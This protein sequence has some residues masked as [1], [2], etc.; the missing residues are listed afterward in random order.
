MLSSL[1]PKQRKQS[2]YYRWHKRLPL[3]GELAQ[4][5]EA[6][7]ITWG[8]WVQEGKHYAV[9]AGS[10][11]N[12]EPAPNKNYLS[13]LS[14][15]YEHQEFAEP[16]FDLPWLIVLR[17]FN[18]YKLH[19]QLNL[20]LPAV[21][22]TWQGW[23]DL[24]T[25]WY[26]SIA[27]C[28][29][30]SKE[31]GYLSWL[32]QQQD[33][34]LVDALFFDLMHEPASPS[35]QLSI[36][37]SHHK[38]VNHLSETTTLDAQED[39]SSWSIRIEQVKDLCHQQKLSKAVLAR[40]WEKKPI[41]G[42]HWSGAKLFKKLLKKSQN[43]E[44][45]FAFSLVPDVTFVGLSP[46]KLFSLKQNMMQSHALAG[47]RILNKQMSEAEKETLISEL[48]T[49][50]KDQQE[51]QIVVDQI[52]ERLS[53]LCD[54][55][56]IGHQGIKN[57]RHLVHLETEL[58]GQLKTD[59]NAF[60]LLESLHPTP[61]LGGAPRNSALSL[62]D[63]RE[64]FH[65]G[66]YAAPWLWGN[67]KSEMT[68]VV[69]IR[70]ALV[71]KDKAFVFAGAGIVAESVSELEWEETQ[72]KAEVI[73]TLLD[74]RVCK[75]TSTEEYIRAEQASFAQS[76][77]WRSLS[78]V[79]QMIKA[80]LCGAV[81]SPGSRNTPLALALT[82]LLPSEICVDERSAAFVALGWAK[83]A[84]APVALCCTSGSAGA[85]YLPAL[86]EAWHSSIPMVIMTAD[87]PPR[88]RH[89][90]AA[91][92]IQQVNLYGHYVK[93]H[94]DLPV[95]ELQANTHSRVALVEIWSNLGEI[96]VKQSLEAPCSPVHLNVP[97][98]EPLWDL[99]CDD[100][101][102]M[103]PSD[104]QSEQSSAPHPQV[105]FIP[106]PTQ[107]SP[108][109]HCSHQK[110]IDDLRVALLKC[111]GLI[112][113][114]PLSPH[115]AEQLK[116][117]LER[118]AELKSWSIVAEASSQFRSE[119]WALSS[120]DALARN[121]STLK[122]HN[123]V[124]LAQSCDCLLMIGGAPH[125][126]AVRA[127][128]KQTRLK[129]AYCLGSGPDTVDP[130]EQGLTRLGQ[131]LDEG[132][133][134]IQTALDC[135]FLD[136][137]NSEQDP[138]FTTQN[139][140]DWLRLWSTLE[141]SWRI[142][143][144]RFE[145]LSSLSTFDHSSQR[146]W[147][148][149]IIRKLMEHL[150]QCMPSIHDSKRS[151]LHRADDSVDIIVASSMAFRDHD[152]LWMSHSETSA[153]QT[154]VWVN[155]GA[156]GIDGTFSTALGIARGLHSSAPLVIHLGDLASYHDIQGLHKLAQWHHQNQSPR[157]IVI[158]MVN[159]DGGGI[160]QHLPIR[161]TKSFESLFQTSLSL[162]PTAAVN[163]INIA[164]SFKWNGYQA[165][166]SQELSHYLQQALVTKQL[167]FIEV[168]V[169]P[170]S[171]LERHQEFWQGFNEFMNRHLIGGKS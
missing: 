80:G 139:Q 92:T 75:S 34:S 28:Y 164:Q 77:L 22:Q 18:D 101:L 25:V 156:N 11:E 48:K 73:A 31:T 59:V 96:A 105:S 146:L 97:F 141:N 50:Q 71:H 78:M 135:A 167:S 60:Q 119:A 123:K 68:A 144:E 82:Q 118:I 88:L 94:F 151:H 137:N 42:H 86:I 8:A 142:Y 79:S 57:L 104:I 70:S 95:E 36:H 9:F 74:T 27:L 155:R 116:P 4:R 170:K 63:E 165:N 133:N 110:V 149:S 108:P 40:S 134:I 55:L 147:G 6:L 53:P 98:E 61:A 154:R 7:G 10:T 38:D 124:P 130:D 69:G 153:F 83:S 107:V 87:R 43:N 168:I 127:W 159:N 32:K 112:Y 54:Q 29:D 128:L 100:L 122:L 19:S 17:R 47:T 5:A 72:A 129:Y 136:L 49:A 67:H 85:H 2:P 103:F 102:G 37:D 145:T 114:G 3:I 157:P 66:G 109:S 163:W 169:N 45:P 120:F 125:S 143:I 51:H 89:R 62:I 23:G 161:K 84:H 106:T 152:M 52:K 39:F 93:Q 132:L 44:I 16:L 90:G 140:P 13:Q 35:P 160:F 30:E 91:Q 64:P 81:I 26:P 113:C 126:R 138:R 115:E 99:G 33:M 24:G 1:W 15:L 14:S 158:L 111:R 76:S 21:D 46:E 117:L 20:S 131:S 148:G 171:D 65:R 166:H 12:Y 58:C 150:H 41:T 121:Y 56:T 162:S